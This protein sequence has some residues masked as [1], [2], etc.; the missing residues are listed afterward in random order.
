MK[1]TRAIVMVGKAV[2]NKAKKEVTRVDD[3]VGARL[4]SVAKRIASGPEPKAVEPDMQD[5]V[6][7]CTAIPVFPVFQHG[8]WERIK[9]MAC[10][11]T[12]GMAKTALV[13][14]VVAGGTL[15]VTGWL[16]LLVVGSGAV[17]LAAGSAV[18]L[19]KVKPSKC[20]E[21]V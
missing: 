2:W 13:S 15:A 20:I 9:R 14:G 21:Q 12:R 5:R 3:C 6:Q 1:T 8:R 11:S 19:C 18:V 10:C 17:A 4:G 7:T 16:P